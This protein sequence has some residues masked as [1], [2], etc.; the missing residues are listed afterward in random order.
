[1]RCP[2]SLAAPPRAALSR[3]GHTAKQANLPATCSTPA[4]AH[5]KKR[6]WS[7]EVARPHRKKPPAVKYHQPNQLSVGLQFRTASRTLADCVKLHG[8]WL[9][10]RS[11]WAVTGVHLNYPGKVRWRHLPSRCCWWPPDQAWRNPPVTAFRATGWSPGLGC[12]FSPAVHETTHV[13]PSGIHPR[14]RP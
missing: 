2:S 3:C 6:P 14:M 9:V 8:A 7:W 10:S 4:A 1:M 12:S 13:T 5:R 11:Q